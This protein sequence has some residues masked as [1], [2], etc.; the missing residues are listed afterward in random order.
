[1]LVKV[2]NPAIVFEKKMRGVN[3]GELCDFVVRASRLVRLRGALSV[4][5]TGNYGIRRLNSRFRG[6]DRPTDVLSFP[7]AAGEDLAGDIAISIEIAAYN[8]RALGHSIS[9]EIRILIL[10]GILHLA[11]YDHENDDGE[12]AKKEMSLRRRFRLPNSLIERNAA[13]RT[14]KKPARIALGRSRT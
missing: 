4:L 13:T 2:N 14:R 1:M 11:G 10:H 8:A 3:S 7:P 9:D 6:K 5:I 12:M